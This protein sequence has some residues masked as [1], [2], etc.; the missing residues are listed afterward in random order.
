MAH[1]LLDAAKL[2]TDTLKRNVVSVFPQISPVLELMPFVDIPGG[3]YKFNREEA[4]PGVGFRG[5]NEDYSE[6][7]GLLQQ[8]VETTRVLGGKSKTDR[9][10]AVERGSSLGELRAVNDR[11]SAKSAALYFTRMFF[12]GD[13]SDDPRQ[14]DG[15]NRRLTGPQLISA[16]DNGAVLT[17]NMLDDLIDAVAGEPDV[18]FMSKA[19]RRELTKLLRNDARIS[20]GSDAFGNQVAMYGG[21]PIRVIEEDG[22][23]AQILGFDEEQGTSDE[24]GS[25]Y[26]VRFGAEEFVHGIQNGPL[27][28]ID[29]GLQEGMYYLTAIEWLA[30]FVVLHP[31]AAARLKGVLKSE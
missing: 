10:L 23:G 31:R 18:L 14:F 12:K 4:L 19:M 29:L 21:I 13:S 1:T 2:E 7:T 11:L 25:I 24:C 15:L 27:E 8:V 28:V 3:A 20:Y 9:A 6:S 30:S 17:V 16:G 5:I 22:H 26:A